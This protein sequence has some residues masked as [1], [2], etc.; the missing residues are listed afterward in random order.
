MRNCTFWIN[1]RSIVI[2]IDSL[3]PPHFFSSIS[4][5]PR[6]SLALLL[7][8]QVPIP[9]PP[10]RPPRRRLARQGRRR[11]EGPLGH[12]GGERS[13]VQWASFEALFILRANIY[14]L[15]NW[16]SSMDF[17]L[18]CSAGEE[19]HCIYA[20]QFDIVSPKKCIFFIRIFLFFFYSG[21]QEQQ[22]ADFGRQR[23]GRGLRQRSAQGPRR[24]HLPPAMPGAGQDSGRYLSNILNFPNKE[25]LWIVKNK[26]TKPLE[27]L[28]PPRWGAIFTRIWR[29]QSSR[30]FSDRW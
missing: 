17:H 14:K 11:R 9:P 7:L 18:W 3:F 25:A 10:L 15:I 8:D 24:V 26:K 20:T 16:H 6:L 4:S 2:K 13:E 12:A 5:D 28:L 27:P 30:I 1:F 19:S 21:W 23:R 22:R 29:L